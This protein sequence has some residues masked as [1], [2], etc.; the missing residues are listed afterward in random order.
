MNARAARAGVAA[1][2]AIVL[3]LAVVAV[4]NAFAY[5]AIGGYDA[6]EYITYADEVVTRRSLPD[7]VGVYHT[8][9][10]YP[11]VA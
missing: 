7:G 1:S 5:P 8:P 10:G 2:A 6:Q 4:R 9:P 11:A 3:A